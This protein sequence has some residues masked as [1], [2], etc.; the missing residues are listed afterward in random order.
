MKFRI[1]KYVLLL[2]AFLLAGCR[3]TGNSRG[4]T[5][6]QV[7]PTLAGPI[8]VPTI[9]AVAPSAIPATAVSPTSTPNEETVEPGIAA[10]AAG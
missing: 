3:W 1:L 7:T 10:T 6:P 5:P 8:I 9:A 4:P 2:A